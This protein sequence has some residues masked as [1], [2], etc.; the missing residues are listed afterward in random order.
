M[1]EAEGEEECVREE[2]QEGVEVRTVK[3]EGDGCMVTNTFTHT[4]T[5]THS[6]THLQ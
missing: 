3:G 6:H 5:H 4:H 2:R 1:G